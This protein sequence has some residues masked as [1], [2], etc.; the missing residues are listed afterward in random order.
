MEFVA[1]DVVSVGLRDSD[2]EVM[3]TAAAA[4]ADSSDVKLKRRPAMFAI[5]S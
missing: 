5:S 2:V 1:S 4:Y 3:L